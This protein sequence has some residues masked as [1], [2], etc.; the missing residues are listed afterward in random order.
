M[1]SICW[2]I[3]I[4]KY[5]L[6]YCP[7]SLLMCISEFSGG[8]VCLVQCTSPFLKPQ[9]LKEAVQLL[10]THDSV[11]AAFRSHSL[12][13]AQKSEFPR[14]VNVSSILLIQP[15]IVI[16]I[17]VKD[18][19]ALFLFNVLFWTKNINKVS[20]KYFYDR[21]M[22]SIKKELSTVDDGRAVS[23]VCW[24]RNSNFGCRRRERCGASEPETRL[25]PL[26]PTLVWRLVRGWHVLPDTRFQCDTARP[27]TGGQV[28][29]I[30]VVFQGGREVVVVM[31]V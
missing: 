25:S 3:L 9:Y 28:I 2:G 22:C 27:T 30:M 4:L 1:I 5:I 6:F 8:V 10:S 29:V 13:W 7:N 14:A 21:N 16:T 23:V 26:P 31:V 18:N 15:S 19:H 24:R 20:I 17:W 11:F 12:R